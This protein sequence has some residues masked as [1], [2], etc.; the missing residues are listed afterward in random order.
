M[1]LTIALLPDIN[2]AVSDTDSYISVKIKASLSDPNY[3]GIIFCLIT[4]GGSL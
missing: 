4:A 3:I 2:V 1:M